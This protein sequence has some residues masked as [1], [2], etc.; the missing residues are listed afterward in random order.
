[1]F[2]VYSNV[3]YLSLTSG[4][5]NHRNT[6]LFKFKLLKLLLSVKCPPE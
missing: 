2:G 6:K 3:D 4:N 5:L 1:M